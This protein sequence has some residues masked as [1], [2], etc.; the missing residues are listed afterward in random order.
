[1]QH[2]WRTTLRKHRVLIAIGIFLVVSIGVSIFL[3]AHPKQPFIHFSIQPSRALQKVTAPHAE[4]TALRPNTNTQGP[5]L[6]F[7]PATGATPQFYKNF[8]TLAAQLGYHILS[9]PYAN[10]ATEHQI[11]GTNTECYGSAHQQQLT[12]E[13]GPHLALSSSAAI[14]TTIVSSLQ[15]LAEKDKNG[16]WDYYLQGKTIQWQDIVLAGHS[17]GG[18]LSA[19]IAHEKHVKGV[20]MLASPNDAD[21]RTHVVA[22]W[23]SSNSQTPL[24]RYYGLTNV[25]D[26]YHARTLQDWQAMLPQSKATNIGTKP[27]QG[28]QLFTTIAKTP[29]NGVSPH[30]SVAVDPVYTP[31]WTY[32]L[33]QAKS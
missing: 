14:E 33:N 9:V 21:S 2:V 5:L 3:V 30:F 19:Y 6:I 17:Q 25:I 12:G 16:H 10:K 8:Q 18:G 20:I 32:F 15:T 11:C 31:I 4:I 26:P 13:E 7:L 27:T 24:N 22:D 29:P 28:K 23:L 1:M